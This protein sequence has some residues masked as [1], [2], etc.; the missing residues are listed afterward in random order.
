MADGFNVPS[1]EGL[2]AQ[3]QET[4]AKIPYENIA[5]NQASLK[6]ALGSFLSTFHVASQMNSQRQKL[7]QAL[8]M[9]Y[10]KNDLSERQFSEKQSQDE[11]RHALAVQSLGL[12]ATIAEGAFQNQAER[13][14]IAGETYEL[15]KTRDD[16]LLEGTGALMTSLHSMKTK[17]GEKGFYNE[18]TGIGVDPSVARAMNSPLGRQMLKDRKEDSNLASRRATDANAAEMRSLA[19]DVKDE[20]W[21]GQRADLSPVINIGPEVWKTDPN[22]PGKRYMD[23]GGGQYATLS[24]ARINQLNKR[25]KTITDRQKNIEPQ[26]TDEHVTAQPLGSMSTQSRADRAREALNDPDATAAEKEA[27][28]RILGQ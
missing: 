11:M 20:I 21:K 26:I 1:G 3:Q 9:A 23:L 2:L 7:E 15:K 28:R 22:K 19:N 17:P 5:A 6:T 8:Q 13:T 10:M 16:Q 12:R 14:R 27:A 24:S 25:W 18:I 4:A